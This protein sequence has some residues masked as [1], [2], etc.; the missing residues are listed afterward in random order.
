MVRILILSLLI[1]T[2]LNLNAQKPNFGI[3]AGVNV[4]PFSGGG[5]IFLNEYETPH[6]S[7]GGMG[8][9]AAKIKITPGTEF[10]LGAN[11]IL[12]R[13][14]FHY[15]GNGNW[16]TENYYLLSFQVPFSV[17][18]CFDFAPENGKIKGKIIYG[19]AFNRGNLLAE[20]SGTMEDGETVFSAR[21]Y[22]ALSLEP[23]FFVGPGLI[24]S[25]K[26]NGIFHLNLTVHI[27][28][29]QNLQFNTMIMDNE[30]PVF[31]EQRVRLHYIMLS[32]HYFPKVRKSGVE[33]SKCR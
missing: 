12:H 33:W 27:S 31:K 23:E 14:H 10:I 6:G 19:A 28:P 32:F 16:L 4:V 7:W 30:A 1:S 29:F 25:S 2:A 11:L 13:Y 24:R 5:R 8:G 9:V 15:S 22:P 21:I 26:S 20:K 18:H 3:T 17:N